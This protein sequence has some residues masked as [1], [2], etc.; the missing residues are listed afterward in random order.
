MSATRKCGS[1]NFSEPNNG[2]NR[3]LPYTDKHI[4][5]MIKAVANEETNQ[6]ISLVA[7]A[8]RNNK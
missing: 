3:S 6:L 8:Q 2:H 1:M 7:V 4:R 5:N